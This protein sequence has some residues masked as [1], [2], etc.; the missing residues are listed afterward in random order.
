MKCGL[1]GHGRHVHNRGLDTDSDC[2]LHGCD[3]RGFVRPRPEDPPTMR[4]LV[5]H[6]VGDFS[7]ADLSWLRFLQAVQ[8]T[9]LTVLG[10]GFHR[11]PGGG[12]TGT[13]LLAE[14][15]AA[16]HSWPELDF[17]WVELASCGEP[18]GLELF[19]E[20]LIDRGFADFLAQP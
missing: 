8:G 3:C 13:V 16:V 14:S 1:C 10:T 15:H 17:A 11:F 18:E 2:A 9:G 6:A 5:L 19:R 7:D 12:F 20:G 4:H